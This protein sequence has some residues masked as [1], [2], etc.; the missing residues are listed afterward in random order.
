MFAVVNIITRGAR[1]LGTVQAAAKAGSYGR[2]G[3][4]VLVSEVLDNGPEVV[5]SGLWEDATGRDLYFEE[6]D[7]PSTNQGVSEQMDWDRVYGF[8]G[9][10]AFK[11]LTMQ[12]QY[13]DRNKGVPTG[14]WGTVFNN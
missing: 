13:S 6:F 3:G 4:S 11:G 2:K 10:V 14:S 7:D 1:T 8:M 12:A 5:L 9:T